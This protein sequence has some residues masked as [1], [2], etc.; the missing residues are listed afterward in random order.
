M[1]PSKKLL[2]MPIISLENGEQIG[3]VKGV[4]ID[5]KAIK[6]A[7]LVLEHKGGW[8]KEA[9]VIPMEQVNSIGDHAVTVTHTH[10]VEKASA[11]PEILQLLR[12]GIQLIGTKV[13]TK[14]GTLIGT[15]E[16]FHYEPTQGKITQLEISSTLLDSLFKGKALLPTHLISTLGKHAIIVQEGAT[17][18][19]VRLESGFQ[20]T[21]KSVKE[22]GSKVWNSTL[23]TTKRLG[24]SLSKS[25]EWFT[26]AD[27]EE[28]E[29]TLP[30]KKAL[31]E[32]EKE[33]PLQEKK[34]LS[35]GDGDNKP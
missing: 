8:F 3:R 24:E 28:K 32:E 26:A 19:L 34:E 20:E 23:E 17:E 33:K 22:A 16:E 13:L 14:D 25:V 12:E 10:C 18:K 5:P 29:K 31:P 27:E 9:K 35:E 1:R 7:A 2:A 6:I 4:I 21:V 15:V 30:D 11:I